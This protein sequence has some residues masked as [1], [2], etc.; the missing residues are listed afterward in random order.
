MTERLR[1]A[2]VS[3][4]AELSALYRRA[5]LANAQDRAALL[6]HPKALKLAHEPIAAGQVIV[7]E[8]GAQIV[9][10]ISLRPAGPATQEVSALFVDP[11]SWNQGVGRKLI[12]AARDR[13]AQ[14]GDAILT[15]TGNAHASGFYRACGFDQIGT[16]QTE[17][18]TAV[19][20]QLNID[21]QNLQIQEG[22]ARLS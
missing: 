15:L 2:R 21:P 10:F 19:Q 9:G 8:R 11:G 7:L 20:M 14:A 18:G 6:A 16:T 13:A 1:T 22:T 5:A 12:T 4:H 3:D 17:F